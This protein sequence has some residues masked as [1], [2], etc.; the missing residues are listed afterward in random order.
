MLFQLCLIVDSLKKKTTGTYYI[1]KWLMKALHVVYHMS[2][3]DIPSLNRL[4]FL[5]LEEHN[6]TSGGGG[7]WYL[8]NI[9]YIE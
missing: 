9:A 4:I 6:G 1:Q 3:Q 5:V 8:R 7:I 2:P